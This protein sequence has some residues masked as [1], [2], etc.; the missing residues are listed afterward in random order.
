[1]GNICEVCKEKST[2]SIESRTYY[3][4]MSSSSCPANILEKITP[5]ISTEAHMNYE[6]MLR[7]LRN[8]INILSKIGN[9]GTDPDL[10][11]N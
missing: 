6:L 2:R 8:V 9:E 1:M 10:V 3:L 11:D 5:L 4:T 7:E